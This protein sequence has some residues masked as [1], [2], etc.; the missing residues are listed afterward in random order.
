M[1]ERGRELADCLAALDEAMLGHG[2]F[3]VVEGP[4][5]V[6]KTTLLRAVSRAATARGGRVLTARGL[7]LEQDLAFGVVRQLLEPTI[8]GDRSADD[9]Y[10]GAA[11]P[12][13]RLLTNDVGAEAASDPFA[14]LHSVY[15]VVSSLAERSP[16]VIT[17]DDVHWLDQPSMR[18]LVLM[19]PRVVELPILLV[20]ST[21][22]PHAADEELGRMLADP[23]VRTIRL[24][25]L[26]SAAV[27]IL[28]RERFGE[29]DAEFAETCAELTGG[30]P[31]Y[32][33]ELLREI[34]LRGVRPTA[35][36]AHEARRIGPRSISQSL[37][38]RGRASSEGA[39]VARAVAVLGDSSRIQ[40]VAA[41]A[42]LDRDIAAA[43]A[44]A[45]MA[46]SVLAPQSDLAFVHPIVRSSV[47]EEMQPLERAAAHRRA[48]A[49]LEG[50]GATVV[51]VAIH[52]LAAEPANDP[53][54]VDVLRR[55]ASISAGSGAPDV[56]SRYLERALAEPPTPEDRA[57]LLLQLGHAKEA[58][59]IPGAAADFLA[60]HARLRHCASRADA[61][62]AASLAFASMGDSRSAV[63]MLDAAA[64]ELPSLPRDAALE[65]EARIATMAYFQVET[66]YRYPPRLDRYD[67]D[68]LPGVTPG[69]Q[70]LLSVLGYRRMWLGRDGELAASLVE[71]GLTDELLERLG[72]GSAEVNAAGLAL[73][74]GDHDASADRLIQQM[75]RLSR[76]RGS[77]FGYALAALLRATL[78]NRRGDLADAESAARA[79]LEIVRP[80]RLPVVVSV[81]GAELVVALTERGNYGAADVELTAM[82]LERGTPSDPMYLALLS[83]RGRLRVAQGHVADGLFDLLDCGRRRAQLGN[84]NPLFVPWRAGAAEAHRL[85]GDEDAARRLATDNL[86]NAQA[87]GTPGAI[88]SAERIL[89]LV[90]PE[91]ALD[92]L[93]AAVDSLSGSP[94]RLELAKALVGLGG[95]LRRTDHRTEAREHLL[96]GLD[97]ADRCAARPVSERA[98]SELSALGLRPRHPRLTGFEALTPSEYRVAQMAAEGLSNIEIAQT[99]FVTRKTVEKH[100]GNAYAKLG[101][102]SRRS[103][104]PFFRLEGI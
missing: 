42:G 5:G 37:R 17:I 74:Y 98:R 94:A 75:T 90:D 63:D 101:V 26:S 104:A 40:D 62:I 50:S 65:L 12:A 102:T 89:G 85:L 64:A 56:A 77:R 25:P 72:S 31:F 11:A 46:E 9:V 52:L 82:D 43:A 103:L 73:V 95:A 15:W 70:L 58:A 18:F 8:A 81:A 41:L 30:N 19:Q 54:V 14:M 96:R 59:G 10:S 1:L 21:R 20:A 88:G 78:S 80:S 6:G 4:A 61:A 79:C 16:L 83:A 24:Q 47:Y 69:E 13:A 57:A 3:L 2:R 93:R 84:H 87:W 97:L 29:A 68:S 48:A 27:A 49:I 91:R 100:L 92:W 28:I 36:G 99:L 71:R 44:D 33:E 32:L 55:A 39:A 45:L 60:A 35:S 86:T 34:E 67:P 66:V 7:E 51:R 22:P 38:F 23:D 76:E 53:W